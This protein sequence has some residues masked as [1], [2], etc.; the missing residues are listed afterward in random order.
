MG[1][2]KEALKGIGDVIVDFQSLEVMTLS[3]N[4][5]GMLNEKGQINWAKLLQAAAGQATPDQAVKTAGTLKLVA[6]TRVNFGGDVVQFR[7]DEKLEGMEELIKLHQDAVEAG[8]SARRAVIEFF[9][10]AIRNAV[11]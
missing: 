7:T 4:V 5:S 6:A 2:L 1:T 8:R 10:Q 11:S 3:G 9:A